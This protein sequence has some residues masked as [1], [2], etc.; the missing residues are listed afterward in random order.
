MVSVRAGT[1][2]YTTANITADTTVDTTAQTTAQ[3]T[4]D[5]TTNSI[6]QQLT[7][8]AN[9]QE[10]LISSLLPQLKSALEAPGIEPGLPAWK[11]AMLTIIPPT[12]G[13]L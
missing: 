3:S 6:A 11:A 1:T 2:A 10:G 12:P 5:A 13:S 8:P 9:G 7:Q 4:A